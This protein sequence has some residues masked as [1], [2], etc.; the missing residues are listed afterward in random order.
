MLTPGL[1]VVY[2]TNIIFLIY[3][4]PAWKVKHLRKP[5]IIITII[6]ILHRHGR[7]AMLVKD[8][9]WMHIGTKLTLRYS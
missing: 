9:C 5:Y 4:T 8:K 3:N 2:V 6:Y 1:P 7:K